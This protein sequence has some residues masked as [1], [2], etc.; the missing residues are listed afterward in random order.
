MLKFLRSVA[1]YS[2]TFISSLLFFP[3]AGVSQERSGCFMITSSGQIINLE[4]ICINKNITHQNYQLEP[5]TTNKRIDDLEHESV[6]SPHQEEQPKTDTIRNRKDIS[7]REPVASPD[8]E[9]SRSFKKPERANRSFEQSE[10]PNVISVGPD[11]TK[12][13]SNGDQ[14]LPNGTIRRVR[15]GN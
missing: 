5:D 6:A 2:V 8:E 15:F 12:Y 1:T 3:A 10:D 7:V 4:N 9:T 14:L 11:G 13:Y